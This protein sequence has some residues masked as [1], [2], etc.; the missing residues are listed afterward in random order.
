MRN[1]LVVVVVVVVVVVFVY[2]VPQTAMVIIEP[3]YVLSN[4]VAF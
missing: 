4:N 1:M 3:R 2:N